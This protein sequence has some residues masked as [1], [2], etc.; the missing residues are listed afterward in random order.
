MCQDVLKFQTLSKLVDIH[1]IYLFFSGE[2]NCYVIILHIFKILESHV[3][4]EMEK[5]KNIAQTQ[6]LDLKIAQ[7]TRNSRNIIIHVKRA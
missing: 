5:R 1:P 7:I 6:I 2:G 3:K 4:S